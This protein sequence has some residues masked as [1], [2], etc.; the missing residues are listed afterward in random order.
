[1]LLY[2]ISRDLNT[3]LQLTEVTAATAEYVELANIITIKYSFI[4]IN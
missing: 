2:Y 4:Y 3:I 1:M